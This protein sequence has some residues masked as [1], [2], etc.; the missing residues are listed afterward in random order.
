[1]FLSLWSS[2]QMSKHPF[3][4]GLIYCCL[5]SVLCWHNSTDFFV[6][7]GLERNEDLPPELFPSRTSE[8]KKEENLKTLNFVK[9][10]FINGPRIFFLL[11]LQGILLRKQTLWTHILGIKYHFMQKHFYSLGI[12]SL[13][14]IAWV[15][16]KFG[17]WFSRTSSP[18]CKQ[19]WTWYVLTV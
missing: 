4:L 5:A 3:P 17:V 15:K 10:V 6:K 9:E 1:M 11:F 2:A 16:A 12:F 19:I 7:E 8:E 18:Y 14:T 13:S